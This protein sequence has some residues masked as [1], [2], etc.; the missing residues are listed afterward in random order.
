MALQGRFLSIEHISR[1]ALSTL[2]RFPYT[3]CSAL[4]G[5]ITA[6]YL[7][8]IEAL[9]PP[10][11]GIKLLFCCALG[12]PL[13][14]ALT[15]WA[16]RR[17]WSDA[18]K[19]FFPALGLVLLVIYYFSLPDRI[20]SGMMYP[21]RFFLLALAAH[22][23]VAFLP[24]MGRG[25]REGFWQYN[26]TL[27]LRILLANLYFNVLFAG[28]ALALLAVDHLFGLDVDPKTYPQLGVL[29]VG[30]F[31]TWVF[32]AGVPEKLD[33]LNRSTEYPPGLK[34]FTQFI[35]L[36]L[37]ILYF[38]ILITYELKIL[39]TGNWPQGWVAHLVLWYSVASILSLLLLHPL[40]TQ[41]GNRWITTFGT[42]FFRG[43]IP[44]L[45]ML[46]IA[47]Y[48]RIAE[49]GVTVNRFLVVNMAVGLTLVVL[50]FVLG[51]KRDIRI[52][53]IILF[54]LCV[55]SA[56][57]PFSAFAVSERSQKARLT[58]YLT[59]NGL[60]KEG[61]I[62]PTGTEASE[63]DRREMSSIA[64]YLWEFHGPGAFRD[65]VEPAQLARLATDSVSEWRD[66]LALSLGF[67]YQPSWRMEGDKMHFYFS[68]DEPKRAALALDGWSYL[69][70][71]NWGGV[72]DSIRSYALGTDSCFVV[73]DTSSLVL[74]LSIGADRA[75][76]VP[77]A[78]LPMAEHIVELRATTGASPMEPSSMQFAGTSSGRA[79]EW[80]F[81]QISGTMQDGKSELTYLHARILLG[82]G[83]S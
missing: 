11:A 72:H 21:I 80:Q 69:L 32:L 26:R 83:G 54:V 31:Q 51:K 10:D 78:T 57:G 29:M 30:M 66:T 45:V 20:S 16:E 8:N 62:S 59:K 23:L 7:I 3:L 50:Y 82:A 36:P 38:V 6:I 5:T 46:Y 33:E 17:P 39:V 2:R 81:T 27:F 24:F 25:D 49:Y 28:L 79:S 73:M 13:F 40:Q 19:R 12:L 76:A 65:L 53:P 48:Q 52:I 15:L 37:V 14:T 74:T 60:L 55:V 44:L 63:D 9:E 68:A 18:T 47:I 4:V 75:T 64:V 56:Y 22:F 35:L 58:D 77:A 34:V 41:A 43:L 1:R 71:Y 67:T 42:W 61:K 70:D